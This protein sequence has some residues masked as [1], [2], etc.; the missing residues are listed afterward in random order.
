[1]ALRAAR[2]LCETE[3]PSG[4][5]TLYL[6][7]IHRHGHKLLWP[8]ASYLQ[9]ELKLKSRT[10]AMSISQGCNGAF[11]AASIAFDLISSGVPGEHI[12]VGSDRF[13][14]S[15]FD[16][17]NSDLGTLY[18][19]GAIAIRMGSSKGVYRVLCMVLESETGLESMY[20]D[21]KTSVE[22]PGDHDVK[23]SKRAYLD[24]VGRKGFNSLFVPA[25]HRLRSILLDQ[26]DLASSP[27]EYVVY[28]NV[29]AGLSA[30]LYAGAISDLAHRDMW[31]FGR[32]IGHTGTSDQFLG[33]WELNRTGNLSSGDRVLLIGA[34]NGLG[35]AA[36]VVEKT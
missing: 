8:A 20:R 7:G 26:V 34:G 22:G 2:P 28:P 24:R 10:R 36:M 11:V 15:A 25:L 13:S 23:S 5:N 35:L 17:I 31:E 19:D 18:G 33:L 9:N 29:G 30:Q 1:M 6:T 3:D 32:S 16:R 12:I 27:A 4:I 21:T 14:G